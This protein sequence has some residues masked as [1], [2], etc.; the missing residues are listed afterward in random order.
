MNYKGLALG[1]VTL[2]IILLIVFSFLYSDT[3]YESSIILLTTISSIAWVIVYISTRTLTCVETNTDN[4]KKLICS[5]K[6]S[7][8][9]KIKYGGMQKYGGAIDI[10][11]DNKK[12]LWKIINFLRGPSSPGD[13]ETYRKNYQNEIILNRL[14]Q[15]IDYSLLDNNYG[16][17][18]RGVNFADTLLKSIGIKLIENDTDYVNTDDYVFFNVDPDV[19]LLKP[20]DAGYTLIGKIV[21]TPGHY[22]AYIKKHSSDNWYKIDTLDTIGDIKDIP[23]VEIDEVNLINDDHIPYIW[24]YSKLK[25]GTNGVI[26]RIPFHLLHFNNICYAATPLQLLLTTNLIEIANTNPDTIQTTVIYAQD[27]NNTI[28]L[29][30]QILDNIESEYDVNDDH[31]YLVFNNIENYK[32][33]SDFAD[34][35][36][37]LNYIYSEIEN[38]PKIK[39]EYT[40]TTNNK[41]INQL[42]NW[43]LKLNDIESKIQPDANY[44]NDYRLFNK[45]IDPYNNNN[46][47]NKIENDLQEKI[48]KLIVKLVKISTIK[49]ET[50]N[51]YIIQIVMI[52]GNIYKSDKT[53]DT[54]LNNTFNQTNIYKI[55][56]HINTIKN[57]ILIKNAKIYNSIAIWEIIIKENTE[58]YII[59]QQDLITQLTDNISDDI[60][61]NTKLFKYIINELYN[62]NIK[63]N[64][65]IPSNYIYYYQD[66]KDK[67]KIKIKLELDTYKEFYNECILYIQLLNLIKEYDINEYDE[68]MSI[69]ISATNDTDNDKKDDEDKTNAIQGNLSLLK[70][71]IKYVDYMDRPFEER[72]LENVDMIIANTGPKTKKNNIDI[73]RYDIQ[74][75][76]PSEY[77]QFIYLFHN[78]N[79]IEKMILFNIVYKII[80][81][82]SMLENDINLKLLSNEDKGDELIEEENNEI[83]DDYNQDIDPDAKI[84]SIYYIQRKPI[85]EFIKDNF[86]D[87]K[88]GVLFTN[89]IR[90]RKIIIQKA[91]RLYRLFTKKIEP[92][93]MKTI[94]S[95]I[96]NF[97]NFINNPFITYDE[98]DFGSGEPYSS[99]VNSYSS[100]KIKKISKRYGTDITP[101]DEFYKKILHSNELLS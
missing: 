90:L 56:L 39:N 8:E 89:N 1:C 2:I 72:M 43:I 94:E 18:D 26:D 40:I 29:L 12:K 96:N 66:P 71:M 59:K 22:I 48:K 64:E 31:V 76:M 61:K 20:E 37:F 86:I 51:Y 79:I 16:N 82:K 83:L 100:E 84:P 54:M 81:W 3:I 98:E 85:R 7:R 52:I 68:L 41:L 5:I 11:D 58:T 27:Y 33:T 70:C 47:N 78:K 25:N 13:I 28:I 50:I 97:I 49:N 9:Y 15:D 35:Q 30:D 32:H 92:K 65:I 67:N 10:S 75:F 63:N 87:D 69:P 80:K 4:E 38:L 95:E 62:N 14:L 88:D 60:N 42:D 6:G 91:K 99:Y 53:N 77:K 73:I 45:I 23:E 21:H 34:I 36:D 46:T 17:V 24:L 44:T 101:F 93:D 57:E 74:N 55:N 19:L